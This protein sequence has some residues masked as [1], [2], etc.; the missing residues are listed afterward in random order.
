M[1]NRSAA[2]DHVRCYCLS[3]NM[4]SDS[5]VEADVGAAFFHAAPLEPSAVVLSPWVIFRDVSAPERR[6]DVQLG[7]MR[8]KCV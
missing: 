4:P 6:T 8:V 1:N 3:V 7:I 2:A 5:R